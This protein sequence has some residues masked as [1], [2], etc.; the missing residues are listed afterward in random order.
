MTLTKKHFERFAVII[1]KTEVH[2][3]ERIDSYLLTEL[4]TYFE[5]SNPRFDKYRFVDAIEKYVE[6]LG[7]H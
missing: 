6:K 2:N 4:I 5:E 7:G 1:A 3:G